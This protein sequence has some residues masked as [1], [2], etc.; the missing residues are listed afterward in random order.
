MPERETV[1]SGTEKEKDDGSETEC[2]EIKL[3]NALLSV[4]PELPGTL[5]ESSLIP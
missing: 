5:S 4:K 2:H 3:H 1:Y